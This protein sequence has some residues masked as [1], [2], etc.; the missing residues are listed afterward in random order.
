MTRLAY[1]H[2]EDVLQ[3]MWEMKS[4]NKLTKSEQDNKLNFGANFYLIS[5]FVLLEE[6]Q[7]KE[8]N[9]KQIKSYLATGF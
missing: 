1:L 6:G 2:D 8:K 5:T 3:E 9:R 4:E 7:T